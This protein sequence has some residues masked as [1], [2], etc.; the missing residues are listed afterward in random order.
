MSNV[1]RAH[2]C[3]ISLVALTALALAAGCGAPYKDVDLNR[4]QVT[5]NATP[6]DDPLASTIAA[7]TTASLP[8]DSTQ[9]YR[10]T[11]GDEL[12]I[13]LFSHPE[14]NRF[15]K[16]RPDGRITLPYLGE[17]VAQ[18]KTT[19]DLAQEIQKGYTEVLIQPRVDVIV[20]QLGGRF[21]LLGEVRN[22]GEYAYERRLSLLQAVARAGGFTDT[23]Q[24][25]NFVLIRRRPDG[26]GVAAILDFR[27]YIADP[28]KRGDVEVLPYDIV[29]VPKDKLSRWDNV[30]RK[31]FI[32]M[33]EAQDVLI[34]GY[35]LID[36]NN[37]YKNRYQAP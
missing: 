26:G 33:L 2:R 18:G 36:F 21:Y 16:V 30:A 13:V 24:L 32:H 1:R 22:P 25:T 4:G 23:A 6:G 19:T 8:S 35:G 3:A 15:V 27:Q 34:R 10:I 5:G 12:E 20:N 29:W 11:D 28:K 14:Q 7:G 17:L 31:T 37:V 9:S